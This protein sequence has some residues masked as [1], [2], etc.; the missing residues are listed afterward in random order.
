MAVVKA[1]LVKKSGNHKITWYPASSSD[2]IMHDETL[3][4]TVKDVL[5][6][7]VESVDA[8]EE[9]LPNTGVYLKDANNNIVT[10]P[11]GTGVVA[12]V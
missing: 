2:V 6:V 10:D 3:N 12:L 9:R 11:S 7:V 8:I 4:L 1:S 5:D